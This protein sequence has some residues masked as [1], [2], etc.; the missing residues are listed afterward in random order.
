MELATGEQTHRPIDARAPRFNQAVV[1]VA[2]LAGYLVDARWVVAAMAVALGLGAA[3][4]PAYGPFLQIFKRFVRP[5]LAAATEFEDSRP[6]RFAAAVG[7]VFLVGSATA[8]VLG[9]ETLGWA[10]GLIVA[11]LAGLAAV[12]KLCVGCEMYLF[13]H[14]L[15]ARRVLARRGASPLTVA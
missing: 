6:P 3:F 4:G 1:S 11:G 14:R 9:S 13:A 2:L 8:F 15:L 7:T 5:R 10:L 12:T